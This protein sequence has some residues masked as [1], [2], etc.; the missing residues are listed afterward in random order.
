MKVLSMFEKQKSESLHADLRAINI[1]KCAMCIIMATTDMSTIDEILLDKQAILTTMNVIS[2]H[3]M[4]EKVKKL[5]G[6]QLYS[7][8]NFFLNCHRQALPFAGDCSDC[9]VK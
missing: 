4:E 6:N 5:G 7:H 8:R 1:H 9:V 2:I 3:R